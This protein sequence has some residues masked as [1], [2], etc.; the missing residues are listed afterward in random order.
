ML[1]KCLF[2]VDLLI[3][4]VHCETSYSRVCCSLH[5]V[6]DLFSSCTAVR[7]VLQV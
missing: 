5:H 7:L 6:S 2:S 1:L 4:V 3:T